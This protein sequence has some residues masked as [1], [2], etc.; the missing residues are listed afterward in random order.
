MHIK[1]SVNHLLLLALWIRYLP[2]E[3]HLFG[4]QGFELSLLL[5]LSIFLIHVIK[6][7]LLDHVAVPAR[8]QPCC[9]EIDRLLRVILQA[10]P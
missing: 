3:S 8:F 1:I 5:Q 7:V 10:E 9:V 2:R 4:E 6:V